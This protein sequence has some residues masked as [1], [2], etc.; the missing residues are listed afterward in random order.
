MWALG[1]A[2]NY[3]VPTQAQLAVGWTGYLAAVAALSMTAIV[4]ARRGARAARSR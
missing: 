2:G 1:F 4:S 3:F